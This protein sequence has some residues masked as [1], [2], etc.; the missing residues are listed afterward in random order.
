MSVDRTTASRGAFTL[1]E[2]LVVIAIIGLL[3]AVLLPAFP[4]VRNKARYTQ[5]AAQFGGLDTGLEMFRGEADLRG[6]YPPS[7]SDNDADRQLIADPKGS[8]G[9]EVRICGAQ[10]LVHAMIGADLLGTPGFRDF[11]RDGQWWNDTFKNPPGSGGAYD[12]NPTTGQEER[13]RYGGAGYVD[14]KMRDN[15]KSFKNL[16]DRGMILNLDCDSPPKNIA[17]DERV[18][19]DPWGTPI[20]YYKANRASLRMT[21]DAAEGES[22]I[23]WQEDNGIITGTDDGTLAIEGLDFGAGKTKGRYH[24]IF[25]NDSPPPTFDPEKIPTDP[26]YDDS[27]ARFI[28]DTSVLAR[29]TPVR[30]DSYLL[31]SAGPDARYGTDDDATNWT[32]KAD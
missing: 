1:I 19:V 24:A 11:D 25:V 3:V 8:Q 20:L 30:K 2:I 27:F 15:A 6:T 18:F 17:S 31:I 14:E 4:A 5:V 13:T 9:D 29:P 10:L 32:R 26:A 23:Y 22:G 12:I 28:L 7:A 16:V 21:A